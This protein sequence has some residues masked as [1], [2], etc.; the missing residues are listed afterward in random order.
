MHHRTPAIA[1]VNFVPP[2][3][4]PPQGGMAKVGMAKVFAGAKGGTAQGFVGVILGHG[5]GW[6]H[7]GK[8]L[9]Q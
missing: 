7:L 2:E 8:Q 9:I 1:P 3:I 5:D 4:Y 6:S